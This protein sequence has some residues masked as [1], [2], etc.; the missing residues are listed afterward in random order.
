MRVGEEIKQ[1]CTLKNKGKYEIGFQFTF[2]VGDSK[3]P[4]DV[5]ELFTVVPN[6]GPLIPSD[7]PTQV[8]V[9]FKS[10]DD[11]SIKELPILRCQVSLNLES[12]FLAPESLLSSKSH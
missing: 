3:V 1:T 10:K 4:S 7:R 11:I 5:H 8:Q 6:K 9:T 12:V 2:D